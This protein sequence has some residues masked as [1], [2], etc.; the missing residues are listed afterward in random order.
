MEI[1]PKCGLPTQA[2][3]C[4]E[5][6]KSEQMIKVETEK[7]R[8][9]KYITLV[10]GFSNIDVKTIAR[11]LKQG[12]ACGGTT[13]GDIIE[14]QGNHRGNVKPILVELGFDENSIDD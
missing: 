12:L 14:L 13:K 10:S 7:R 9:G 1:C 4:D 2:C 3:V 11:E 8:Y 5:M 6:G